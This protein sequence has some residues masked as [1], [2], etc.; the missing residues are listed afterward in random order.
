M[1]NLGVDLHTSCE[2]VDPKER[3]RETRFPGRNREDE[4]FCG[5]H[6]QALIVLR[7]KHIPFSS[8][9]AGLAL[10]HVLIQ[11]LLL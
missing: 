6:T 11:F 1:C 7:H 10:C 8:L 2:E 5:I 3:E 9:V 4:K